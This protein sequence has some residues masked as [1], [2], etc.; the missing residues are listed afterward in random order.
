MRIESLQDW[1][2]AVDTHWPDLLRLI[3]R[4]PQPDLEKTISQLADDLLEPLSVRATKIKENKD[5]IGLHLLFQQAWGNAPDDPEIHSYPSWW[6]LCD[7]CSES[8]VFDEDR[9]G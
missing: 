1:W 7:L 2:K 5:H 8:W 4:F 6:L 9:E 3:V